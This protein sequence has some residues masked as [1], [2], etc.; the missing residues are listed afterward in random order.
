MEQS[1]GANFMGNRKVD[2]ASRWV[3]PLLLAVFFVV[4]LFIG[5][6]TGQSVFASGETVTAQAEVTT[7]LKTT[8]PID[9]IIINGTDNSIVPVKLL[10]TNGTLSM[11]TTTGLSFYNASGSPLSNPQTGSVLYFSGTRSDVNAALATLHYTRNTTGTDTLEVSLVSPGEV[12]F[13]GNGHLYEYVSSTLTW[14][15]AKTAAEGRSKYGANGYL[16]TITSQAENDFVSARVLNAGWM[17]AS[18]IASEG[19]WR[20]V[21]G[22]ENGT[23]FSNGN[24]PG[25]TAAPGQYQ[26][27]N[28]GEPNNS[29][30][31]EDCGQFLSGGSGRWN[32][33]P[34]S[35]TTLPGY[36]V[37]YGAPGNMPTVAAANIAITTSD[38]IAPTTPDNLT[39]LS[40][41]TDATPTVSWTTS[42]DSG[43]GLSSPPYTLE[44]SM[45]ATFTNVD[46]SMT[47]NSTSLAPSVNLADGSW[48]FRVKA[49]DNAGNIATSATSSVVVID[50]TPPTTP[51]T[52]SAGVS[53]TNDNTPTWNWTAS[54]DAG[55]GLATTAY[56]IEWS[57]DTSFSNLDGMAS[58]PSDASYTIPDDLSLSD[59]TWY[60]RVKAID[61]LG[62]E[63]LW[64][65][66]GTTR[67]DTVK[68]AIA[69]NGSS[70]ITVIQGVAYTDAGA[71]AV[72]EAEGDISEAIVV[73]NP[74][75]SD[76]VGAYNVTYD[77]TDSAGN[78]ATTIT[79]TVRVV[80]NADLN[81]DGTADAVQ[82]HVQGVT[83]GETGSYAVVQVDDACSLDAVHSKKQSELAN[84]VVYEYPVGLLDFTATC[85]TGGFTTVVTQYYYNPP[86]GD[87]ILRKFMEGSFETVPGVSISQR[88]IDGQQVLV[89]RYTVTDG[90]KLDAD[91]KVDGVIVDPAGPAVLRVPSV[92]ATGVAGVMNM[93]P[94]GGLLHIA[95]IILILF[96]V[97]KIGVKLAER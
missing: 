75:D 28:T 1:Q 38:T 62:H 39:V 40:P 84:D 19:A 80:S 59:G 17:G 70:E 46:G 20:W 77:V 96:G 44:W 12:F 14:N 22:P 69:L 21:T 36:V 64:S 23:I 16:A 88:T 58:I 13:S 8:A 60:F 81:D 42:T 24:A 89:I 61:A 34:C 55:V 30:N 4:T 73:D 18:D 43:T 5:I 86:Q 97:I 85:G 50:T 65:S 67:I 72:D 49:A 87:F 66:Y 92:P 63:S 6:T 74:V 37:E 31:N 29:S 82:Q 10:V 93:S 26:N 79:R 27:W 56:V 7:E 3:R 71:V 15:S 33:L 91:G 25:M 47:T 2:A 68:P 94:S 32:D 76:V 45:N 83:N 53:W 90:G 11:T 51:G 9:G 41:T 48:Y 52:P 54:T 95:P 78:A 35:G 57:Q